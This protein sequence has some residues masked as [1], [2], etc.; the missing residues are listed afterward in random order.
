MLSEEI[1]QQLA[2]MAWILYQVAGELV[3][4]LEVKAI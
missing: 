1:F 4:N 2:V 3:A